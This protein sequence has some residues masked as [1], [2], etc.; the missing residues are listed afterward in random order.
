MSKDTKKPITA[1]EQLEMDIMAEAELARLVRQ[2][3][4]NWCEQCN[5]FL[6]NCIDKETLFCLFAELSGKSLK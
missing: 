2:V 3:S 5:L 4:N 6:R 1:Q